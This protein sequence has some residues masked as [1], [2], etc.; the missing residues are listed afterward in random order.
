[1]VDSKKRKLIDLA[2]HELTN[3]FR[4]K[5]DFYTYLTDNRK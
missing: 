2:D 5:K 1:M 3:R 4:S